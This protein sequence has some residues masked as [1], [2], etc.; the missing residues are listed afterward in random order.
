MNIGSYNEAGAENGKHPGHKA[1]D[2]DGQVPH[3]PSIGV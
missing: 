2:P 3:L 1:I